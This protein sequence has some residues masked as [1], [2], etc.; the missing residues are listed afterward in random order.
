MANADNILVGPVCLPAKLLSPWT[1]VTLEHCRCN[2][3]LEQV[4]ATHGLLILLDEAI[5][6][7][8]DSIIHNW[9]SSHSRK[10]L[11]GRG[12]Q[13]LVHHIKV[14]ALT[15]INLLEH[16]SRDERGSASFL[17][18][19]VQVCVDGQLGLDRIAARVASIALVCSNF[20]LW[21]HWSWKQVLADPDCVWVLEILLFQQSRKH[22]L[23]AVHQCM[24]MELLEVGKHLLGEQHQRQVVRAV[25]VCTD[26]QPW[27]V[28][29]AQVETGQL[30]SH[31]GIDGGYGSILIGHRD[32]T[33]KKEKLSVM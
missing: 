3:R 20:Q 32:H 15:R 13:L 33:G 5:G 17:L 4:G 27:V 9:V 22:L 24:L 30:H 11:R 21:D 7:G 23:A 12:V 29:Q 19:L 2:T 26:Q 1:K 14:P 25:C 6:L 8:L 16:N 28:H 18:V 10:W 31:L